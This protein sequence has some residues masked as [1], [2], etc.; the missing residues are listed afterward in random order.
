[1][2]TIRSFIHSSVCAVVAA[3]WC[4][5]TPLDA[6]QEGPGNEARPALDDG[7]ATGR[8]VPVWAYGSLAD[9]R[10]A[11][12]AATGTALFAVRHRIHIPD[13]TE[14][15]WNYGGL[16]TSSGGIQY[17][18]AFQLSVS[19]ADGAALR[20]GIGVDGQSASA[21]NRPPRL[22]TSLAVLTGCLGSGCI[23]SQCIG[24]GCAGS[25][26]NVSACS[27]SMCGASNCSGS[28]CVFSACTASICI[29]SAC[30]SSGCTLSACTREGCKPE[31][32][33]QGTVEPQ[34]GQSSMFHVSKGV[35]TV[36]SWTPDAA[37]ARDR[38]VVI[39]GSD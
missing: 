34:R 20:A 27:P 22:I 38:L 17:G 7:S 14:Q 9:G 11:V 37:L 18:E 10:S 5:A 35:V 13:M 16:R 6:S 25:A 15:G 39:S 2:S 1:M 29:G 26:C 23:G 33:L 28:S 4:V 12:Q 19:E 21:L 30:L 36:P 24:T 3:A 8:G 32:E 31:P